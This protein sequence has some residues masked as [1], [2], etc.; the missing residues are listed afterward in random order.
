MCPA[1]PAYYPGLPYWA[2]LSGNAEVAT[3]S[4]TPPIRF[5]ELK[6]ESGLNDTFILKNYGQS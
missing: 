4:G 3:L 5:R 1:Y 6:D 2:V